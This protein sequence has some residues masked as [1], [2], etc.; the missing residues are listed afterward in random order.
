MME[1]SGICRILVQALMKYRPECIQIP[2]KLDNYP[3]ASSSTHIL[4]SRPSSLEL[5]ARFCIQM[6]IPDDLLLESS[7]S[8]TLDCEIRTCTM[9]FS[10]SSSLHECSRRCQGVH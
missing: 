4:A 10:P 7:P 3:Q 8:S 1:L 5:H 6:Q 9:P 2:S